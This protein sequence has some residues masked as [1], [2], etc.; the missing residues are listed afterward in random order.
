MSKKVNAHPE[1]VG[2]YQRLLEIV[3][4]VD[5]KPV[6]TLKPKTTRKA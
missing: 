1:K 5:A 4:G 6:Q 3:E 2:L